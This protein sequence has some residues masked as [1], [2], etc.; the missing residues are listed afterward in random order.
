[1]QCSEQK[2]DEMKKLIISVI[3]PSLLLAIS[4]CAGTVTYYD[5]H[6][7]VVKREKVTDFSRMMDGTNQKSQMIMIDGTCIKF[8]ASATAGTNCT[9]GVTIKYANGKTAILNIKEKSPGKT[10]AAIT[11]NFFPKTLKI[12]PSEL[13]RE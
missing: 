1:M 6:G 7:R 12:T 8:E 11:G 9:P 4:G 5:E 10:A 3:F 13:T 2:G